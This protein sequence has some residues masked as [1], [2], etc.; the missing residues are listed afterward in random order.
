[1]GCCLHSVSYVQMCD[2]LCVFATTLSHL[3]KPPNRP[4]PFQQLHNWE[5]GT[6]RDSN[7]SIAFGIIEHYFLVAV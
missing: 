3:L 5:P 2:L 1:M 6:F 4:E 7:P